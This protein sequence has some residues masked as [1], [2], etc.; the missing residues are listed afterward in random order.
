MV[1]V[2]VADPWNLIKGSIQ[3]K[4]N[5]SKALCI[6]LSINIEKTVVG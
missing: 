4:I 1:A 6:F 2:V 3:D 5:D